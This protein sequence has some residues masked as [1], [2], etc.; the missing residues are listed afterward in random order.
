M[1]TPE[2][3][4]TGQVFGCLTVIK[5]FPVPNDTQKY[6]QC[7]C[8]CGNKEIEL[9]SESSLVSKQFIS[10]KHCR[11]KQEVRE[12]LIKTHE[13]APG[14]WIPYLIFSDFEKGFHSK[15]KA[16]SAML[17]FINEKGLDPQEDFKIKE[18]CH[19]KDFTGQV[20]G[21]LTVIKKSF[22]KEYPGGN[23]IAMWLCRCE[24]GN[25]KRI[26]QQIL[27]TGKIKDCGCVKKEKRKNE[28]KNPSLKAIWYRMK[29]TQY[30]KNRACNELNN[31]PVQFHKE[32][33]DSFQVFYDWCIANGWKEG[34]RIRRVDNE[35]DYTPYN[36]VIKTKQE[37]DL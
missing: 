6:W 11:L 4:L 19:N 24:C 34:S 28:P 17:D 22:P 2:T 16:E 32:W 18:K 5:L 14:L 27:R 9:F 26:A 7:Q 13:I 37:F 30:R 35:D 21:K 1:T 15:E 33:S 23:K 29:S 3:D 25:E 10:C 8:F 20:F 31:R 12:N 36:C